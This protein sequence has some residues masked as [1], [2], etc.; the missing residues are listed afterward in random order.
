[1]SLRCRRLSRG[2]AQRGTN[3]PPAGKTLRTLHLGAQ[4]A[5]LRESEE[6]VADMY[7]DRK[8]WE[9]PAYSSTDVAAMLRLPYATVSSWTFGTTY[10]R[11]PHTTRFPPVII[12]AD[13]Q[14]RL[15]SFVNLVEVH[16]LSALRRKHR[17]GLPNIRRAIKY[18]RRKLESQ[19]PLAEKEMR[20]DG[21]D[22]FVEYLGQLVNASQEGQE[23]IRSALMQYLKRVDRDR[24]GA[25]VRLFP[26]TRLQIETAPKS[27]A[28]DPRQ[29]F[30]RPFLVSC[31]IETSVIVDRY[32]AGDS[33]DELV[34]D[35]KA[36]RADIE[37]AVRYESLAV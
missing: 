25:T 16:V 7:R 13:R 36:K 31:G 11:K 24:L 15:L 22:I 35:L 1:M 8:P 30:G 23:G 28:I 12:P 17:V 9:L 5:I 20:T 2:R 3:A 26:F 6:T 32:R 27:V 37:E 18:L 10:G 29:R 4:L 14:K 34:E 19:H 21:K 33:I